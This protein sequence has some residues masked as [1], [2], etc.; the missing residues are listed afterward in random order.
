MGYETGCFYR[1]SGILSDSFDRLR[2]QRFLE[3]SGNGDQEFVDNEETV[4]AD[5]DPDAT[6]D[7]E[8]IPGDEE[9]THQVT[10]DSRGGSDV[11]SQ[12]VPHGN[13]AEEPEDPEK[14]GCG[15]TG[16]FEDEELSDEWDF[17]ADIVTADTTLYAGWN[18]S[19]I[20]VDAGEDMVVCDIADAIATD[21]NAENYS[22]LE[23]KTS[24]DGTFSDSSELSA[25][26]SP[27]SSD[28]QS[29]HVTLT[30]TAS[31]SQTGEGSVSDSVDIDITPSP[32]ISTETIEPLCPGE[33][34]TLKSVASNYSAV[35]WKAI[36]GKGTLTDADQLT[37]GYEPSDLD[38]FLGYTDFVVRATPLSPCDEVHEARVRATYA[39]PPEIDAGS[40]QLEV[41]GTSTNMLA[42]ELPAGGSGI[43]TIE[44]GLGGVLD[45]AT[46]PQSGFS[47]VIDQSY[48]LK[49]T[50][51][52]ANGCTHSESVSVSFEVAT[53]P[54]P[55][56]GMDI[57]GDIDDNMYRTT[58]IGNQ[59]WTRDNLRTTRY[60]DG[61]AIPNLGGSLELWGTTTTG[62]Y[63]WYNNDA[64]WKDIYG[65]L[66]NW[67]AVNH[68]NLCPSGWHVPTQP[69]FQEMSDYVYNVHMNYR[70][71]LLKS[72]RQV[73]SSQGGDCATTEHPRWDASQYDGIDAVG[74]SAIPGGRIVNPNVTVFEYKNIGLDCYFWTS[75]ADSQNGNPFPVGMHAD[76]RNFEIWS[77]TGTAPIYGFSIRCMKDE[78]VETRAPIVTTHQVEQLHW[79][80]ARTGGTV[81]DEGMSE[82]TAR[83][84]VWALT[85]EPTVE[86]HLGKTENGED[87]GAYKSMMRNLEPEKT[88]YIRAYATNYFGTS[89]GESVT[90]T[91]TKYVPEVTYHSV[92]DI[93]ATTAV[94]G[95]TITDNEAGQTAYA[96]GLVWSKTPEPTV[97][98]HEGMTADGTGVGMF[99]STMTGLT[100]ESTYYVRAYAQNELGTGYAQQMTFD[101]PEAGVGDPCNGQTTMQD[102]RDSREYGIVQIGNQCWMDENL[103]YLPDVSPWEE[104][105]DAGERYY[106]SDYRGTDVSEAVN[107]DYY[108]QYGVQYNWLAALDACPSDWHLPS[109]A[110]WETL[111]GEMS[112]GFDCGGNQLKSCRTVDSPLGGSCNVTEHPRWES[113]PT[114][115]PLYGTDDYAFHGLPGGYISSFSTNSGWFVLPGRHSHWWTSTD[116]EPKAYGMSLSYMNSYWHMTTYPQSNGLNI[117]CVKD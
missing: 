27:G 29:G 9:I 52:D 43:W 74:F 98:D 39:K 16:W 73:D 7:E 80:T 26:Y 48:L 8:A 113:S 6:D 58:A 96:R 23:W 40:D 45:D 86:V 42:S 32:E 75:S 56:N 81:T 72:C 66:Y 53:P 19:S 60:D 93:T 64:S 46:D 90:L 3:R 4:P 33:S 47:G 28:R 95:G 99:S 30:L 37:A 103:A 62:A 1:N 21:A 94:T 107:T 97:E 101:T 111:Q 49:W 24:G 117:R 67:H 36:N 91:T 20:L 17:A 105:T 114:V 51:T 79:D 106:V 13:L 54:D 50:V 35:E 12:Q 44:N 10:F 88:Y 82:V 38:R 110:D 104:I 70:G 41:Q 102:T 89:Y 14:S 63:A 78:T 61:S 100:P 85:T 55:C 25:V 18:C 59:C 112:G 92:S 116:D 2:Q 15:F 31:P 34:V 76:S 22:F 68:G 11:E 115:D 57:I 65:G 83:G 5:E 109:K 71:T 77:G 108:K 69:E 84:V 87:T